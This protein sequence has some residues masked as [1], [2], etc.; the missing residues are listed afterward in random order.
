MG[1][2]RRSAVGRSGTRRVTRSPSRFIATC[3]IIP[4]ASRSPSC[5]TD[6]S[7]SSRGADQRSLEAL[8]KAGRAEC[9]KN[10][11]P[12]GGRPAELWIAITPEPATHLE[13]SDGPVLTRAA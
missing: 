10:K 9:R 3:W 1:L 12:N 13:P 4:G 5:T 2:C 8:E 11:N 6:A 7:Q